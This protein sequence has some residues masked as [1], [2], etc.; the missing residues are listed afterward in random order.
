MAQNIEAATPGH[1]LASAQER[2]DGDEAREDVGDGVGRGAASVLSHRR[3]PQDMLG[4]PCGSVGCPS[5]TG[6]VH[7]ALAMM[8][9]GPMPVGA[10]AL[11]HHM[12]G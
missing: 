9:H 6:S 10:I 1:P 12:F 5:S 7:M 4:Q 2:R 8:L 3:L 11:I